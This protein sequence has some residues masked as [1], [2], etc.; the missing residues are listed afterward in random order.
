MLTIKNMELTCEGS[1]HTSDSAFLPSQRAAASS[2]F[3]V[4]MSN[5]RDEGGV[6]GGP[7]L[8]NVIVAAEA[9]KNDQHTH[10][11]TAA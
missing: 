1:M 3:Y 5:Q 2:V 8:L 11:H 10:T 6:Y 4:L 9:K 7:A